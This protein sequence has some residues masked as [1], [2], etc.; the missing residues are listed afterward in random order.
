M[1]KSRITI[2]ESCYFEQDGEG[3]VVVENRFSREVEG[4]DQPYVRNLKIGPEWMPLQYGWVE[5]PGLITITN[6]EG[7]DQQLIPTEEQAHQLATRH[8]D[9]SFREPRMVDQRIPP[10]ESCRIFPTENTNIYLRSPNGQIKVCVN[11][12][13]G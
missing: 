2:V 9:I 10:G 12:F 1:S 8:L 5:A 7:E 4:Q 3:P 11:I 13:P 6:R